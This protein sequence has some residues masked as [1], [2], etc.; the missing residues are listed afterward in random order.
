MEPWGQHSLES[1][2]LRNNC[3]RLID[4][5]SDDVLATMLVQ[6]GRTLEE[7]RLA[8]LEDSED[9]QPSYISP[10]SAHIVRSIARTR[11]PAPWS[12]TEEEDIQ[13]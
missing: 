1:A 2:E 9:T 12:S 10:Q 5:A 13:D 6:L 8:E 4:L 3:Y 7:K 11:M